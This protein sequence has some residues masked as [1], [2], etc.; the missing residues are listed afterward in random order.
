MATRPTGIAD[1]Y[2]RDVLPALTRRLDVAFP[3]FALAYA[4]PTAGAPP[5]KHSRTPASACAPTAS[6]ATATPPRL[7]HPRPR[8]DALDDL[9]QRRSARPRP[10]LRR[11]PSAH[12]RNAPASTPSNLDRPPTRVER[13]ANLLH[14][15]FVLCRRELASDRG[16]IRPRIPRIARHPRRPNRRVRPRAH[17]R[18]HSPAPRTRKPRVQRRRDL[19]LE[20]HRRLALAGPDRRR[21]ARRA[22]PRDHPLGSQPSHRSPT[23]AISISRSSTRPA[24][25]PYGLSTH[26]RQRIAHRSP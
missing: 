1:F 17:A 10:R 24:T 22:Q 19:R 21:M 3:E 12:S 25:M 20:R 18:R 7:P 15:A 5:I 9:P 23:I 2:E 4:T 11:Q 13:R 8:R 14:D 6:S 26:P 16:A